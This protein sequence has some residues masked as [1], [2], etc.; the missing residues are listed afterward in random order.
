MF[1]YVCLFGTL[2]GN[3]YN[4]RQINFQ[5][6]RAKALIMPLNFPVGS[7]LQ[8][9]QFWTKFWRSGPIVRVCQHERQYYFIIKVVSLFFGGGEGLSNI[10]AVPESLSMQWGHVHGATFVSWCSLIVLK[11]KQ[12]YLI[13]ERV[14]FFSVKQEK[15]TAKIRCQT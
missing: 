2:P 12:Y 4:Y 1:V 5:N 3:S 11:F 6:I 7:T 8:L 13:T 10:G 14:T 15:S 9:G